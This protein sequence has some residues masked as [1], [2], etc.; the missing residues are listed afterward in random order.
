MTTRRDD[1]LAAMIRDLDRASCERLLT[2]VSIQCYEHESDAELREA[3]AA[4]YKDG[5]I[6]GDDLLS[7][8]DECATDGAKRFRE[9][10]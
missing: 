3:V 8:W 4:N 6:S 2:A 7:A 10:P 9:R 5:T 1:L